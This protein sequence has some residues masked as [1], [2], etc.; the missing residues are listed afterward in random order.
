MLPETLE[1]FG[2]PITLAFANDGRVYLTERITGRLWRID[3]EAQQVIRTFPVAPL[4]GHNETG[5]LGLALDPAFDT[6]GYIY[7]YYTAGESDKDFKN[8]VVRVTEDGW[9]AAAR[10]DGSWRFCWLPPRDCSPRNS[11][12]KPTSSP[13]RC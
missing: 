3:H 10:G 2:F 12:C 4:L 9:V 6:N 7:C 13:S 8:R 1:D 5:L 11:T